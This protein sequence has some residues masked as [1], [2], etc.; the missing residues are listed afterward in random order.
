MARAEVSSAIQEAKIT[1]GWMDAVSLYL[2]KRV[3]DYG[4][5]LFAHSAETKA[6]TSYQLYDYLGHRLFGY[7]LTM[8][9]CAPEVEVMTELRV[10]AGF[11]SAAKISADAKDTVAEGIDT[12]NSDAASGISC[13]QFGDIVSAKT[14]APLASDVK[15]KEKLLNAGSQDVTGGAESLP[16]LFVTDDVNQFLAKVMKELGS[17]GGGRGGAGLG[18]MSSGAA[19]FGGGT[20][21]SLPGAQDGAKNQNVVLDRISSA[22]RKKDPAADDFFKTLM[23]KKPRDGESKSSSVVSGSGE[24]GPSSSA[25]VASS[26]A[27]P[28]AGGSRGSIASSAAES[29]KEKLARLKAAK[30]N[31]PSILKTGAEKGSTT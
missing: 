11:D 3:R 16:P 4:G 15:M 24:G 14:L 23:Q 21:K 2:R 28:G 31:R 12:G 22:D 27:V 30:L 29:V 9:N 17:E 5:A 6:R 10:P 25:G 19:A 13:K 8:E 26:S 18:A 7:E 1:K 20:P